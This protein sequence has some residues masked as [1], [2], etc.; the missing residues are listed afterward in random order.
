MLD[1]NSKMMYPLGIDDIDDENVPWW[2][3]ARLCLAVMGFVGFLT[4]YMQK[5][6]MSIA[7]ICMINQ[8]AVTGVDEFTI[9]FTDVPADP[10]CLSKSV[11]IGNTSQDYT[12]DGEFDW[13]S[14][15]QSVIFSTFY[16]GFLLIQIP[17]GWLSN[18][19]GGKIVFG[20]FL[21]IESLSSLLTPLAART[22][23]LLLTMLR[24]LGGV[25]AGAAFPSMHTLLG[26]WA[27]PL[28]RSNLASISYSGGFMGNVIALPGS[29][30]LCAYGFLGG[31]PSIFYSFGGF[32]VIVVVF[33]FLL[34]HESPLTHPR[35][36]NEEKEYIRLS[37]Q[38]QANLSLEK[39]MQVPWIKLMTS[40]PF[41]A[42]VFSSF[43]SEWGLYTFEVT[44][45]KYM[46]EILMFDIRSN[47]VFL[48]IPYIAM[49]VTIIL[50]GIWSD[51]L[52]RK[53]VLGTT[54][55]RKIMESTGKLMP[56]GA[57]IALSFLPCKHWMA[58]V[59]VLAA[60]VAFSGFEFNGY[61]VNP[62][63]IAPR[64]AG[65]IIGISKTVGAIAGFTSP[66][67][68]HT[69]T[70][71]NTKEQWQTVFFISAS[72]YVFGAL[73]FL[74]C[75]SG[76]LQQWAM[77]YVE[78]P[79][80]AD[81]LIVP[82]WPPPSSQI[83]TLPRQTSHLG[84]LHRPMSAND[85]LALYGTLTRNPSRKGGG[86]MDTL[87][88]PEVALSGGSSTS[89]RQS[90]AEDRHSGTRHETAPPLNV[91][92]TRLNDKRD[93]HHH[94]HH[95]NRPG[96][97]IDFSEPSSPLSLEGNTPASAF[98]DVSA[99]SAAK[100][101]R[102]HSLPVKQRKSPHGPSR[103]KSTK[104]GRTAGKKAEAPLIDTDREDSGGTLSRK[105][106]GKGGNS[107]SDHTLSRRTGANKMSDVHV[108]SPGG[109]KKQP[110]ANH[111][112]QVSSPTKKRRSGKK[113]RARSDDETD[114]LYDTLGESAV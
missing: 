45:P 103:S 77:D 57:L 94:H 37:L 42:I 30:Y 44:M 62:L 38:G 78:P 20:V 31:W 56:A 12:R 85:P 53:G 8:T 10:T 106:S 49:L 67:L 107:D 6:C 66:F 19:Y 11:Q 29:G 73:V 58:A 51:Q 25:G 95:S 63:D 52:R 39:T 36:T 79:E 105:S 21:L 114:N 92:L 23:Y 40:V 5:A 32:G 81:I 82:D 34:V 93:K 86:V 48:A 7:M 54:V 47:G 90:S 71:E 27:P 104:T 13:S 70:S 26:R 22:H 41:I 102:H 108:T 89:S 28:E 15:K 55:T 16:W 14:T 1:Y 50:S 109:K 3:S 76:D 65:V 74:F 17:A 18:R 9:N 4:M 97:P 68:V 88:P 110:D 113:T 99:A 2:C 72:F 100:K 46:K 35:I 112:Q 64:Y 80:S 59:G 69:I 43:T 91:D 61:M 33:W 75:G 24:F 83:T 96:S 101:T 60:G 98:K 87:K 111:S 84:A